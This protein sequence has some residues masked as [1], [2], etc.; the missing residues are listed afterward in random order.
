MKSGFGLLGAIL[1]GA[2][3]LALPA[4]AKRLGGGKSIG[5]QRETVTQRQAT[6]PAPAATQTSPSA[7]A[8]AAAA[9]AAPA[10]SGARR[11]LGPIAGIAA[12]LGLAALF[13]HFGLG[14][15]FASLLLVVLL[16]IGVVVLVRFLLRRNAP[17][18]TRGMA[19]A[20]P[21]PAAHG[22]HTPHGYETQAAPQTAPGERFGSRQGG[23]EEAKIPEGFDVEQ[24]L[25]HAKLNFTSL[26]Q[27][28]DRGDLL[29][30]KDLTTPEM[31]EEVKRDLEARG[32][33]SNE[34]QVL[35][36]DASMVEVVQEKQVAWA[37]VRFSGLVRERPED[38]A[39]SF[40]EVWNLRKDLAAGEGW[41]L[42]GIQQFN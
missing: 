14:E 20:G 17:A 8:P 32:G 18:P 33:T 26:Q 40:D 39:T 21:A 13:S 3:V 42:A 22:L 37:S 7:A 1:I 4:E 38:P 27:A 30:L 28:F 9:A 34:T 31:L 6:P 16:V 24:F 11:W 5:A 15:G 10:A 29:A 41:L 2:T 35:K 23:P 19:Y 12:G 36:L 25:K